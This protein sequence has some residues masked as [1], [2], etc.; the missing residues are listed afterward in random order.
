MFKRKNF[1]IEDTMQEDIEILKKH[2][3][4]PTDVAVIRAGIG[5][6]WKDTF[7]YGTDPRLNLNSS[8][9]S[10][11]ESIAERKVKLKIA[12]EKVKEDLKNQP[13]INRCIYD[14]GGEVITNSDGSMTCKWQT[15]DTRHS[16]DQ[17]VG[18]EQCGEYLL[19]NLFIP[20]RATVLKARP[21]LNEK[22][23]KN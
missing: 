21:E 15:H 7:K 16:Y 6:L 18:I 12:E 3:R 14:L 4:I 20:D 1:L 13:K 19:N 23:G 9:T 8:S 22:F 2:L 5:C 11:L 17:E 10:S